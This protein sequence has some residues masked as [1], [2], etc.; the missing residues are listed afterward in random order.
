ML[1]PGGLPCLSQSPDVFSPNLE[2]P[3][4]PQAAGV[5]GSVGSWLNEGVSGCCVW[6]FFLGGVNE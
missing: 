1:R 5:V 4:D 2:W 6:F 3:E